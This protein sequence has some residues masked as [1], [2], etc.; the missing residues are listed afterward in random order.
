MLDIRMVNESPRDGGALDMMTGGGGCEIP[1]G[2]AMETW[3]GGGVDPDRTS[4]V[5]RSRTR[6]KMS[7]ERA[8]IRVKRTSSP[9]G[10]G[11]PGGWWVTTCPSPRKTGAPDART[12]SNLISSPGSRA[13][14]LGRRIAVRPR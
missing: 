7:F 8:S 2:G 12:I 11:P 6:S 4:A 9:T 3:A 10:L 1:D 13:G 5:R 14:A